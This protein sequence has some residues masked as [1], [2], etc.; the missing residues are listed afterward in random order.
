MR[1]GLIKPEVLN[2]VRQIPYVPFVL[3]MESGDRILVKHPENIALDPDSNG[4]SKLPDFCV[5]TRRFRYYGTF[6]AVTGI[7]IA[8]NEL[9]G[10]Q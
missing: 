5:F 8:D 10:N 1:A 2:R 3:H 4:P 9:V 6:E 7:S